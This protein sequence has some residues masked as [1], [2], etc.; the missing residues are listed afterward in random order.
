MGN[1]VVSNSATLLKQNLAILETN[2]Y[3]EEGAHKVWT[4]LK[5]AVRADN[6]NLMTILEQ[7]KAG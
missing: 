7:A 6:A 4:E 1:K 2:E 5:K 3:I